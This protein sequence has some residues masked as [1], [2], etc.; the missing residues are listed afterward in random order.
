MVQV[1]EK[2]EIEDLLKVREHFVESFPVVEECIES[3]EGKEEQS[4]SRSFIKKLSKRIGNS[5]SNAKNVEE[6]RHIDKVKR[7]LPISGRFYMG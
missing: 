5:K 2:R 7:Q 6:L 4:K 3:K 1:Y